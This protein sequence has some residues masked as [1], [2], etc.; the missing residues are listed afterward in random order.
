M[1]KGKVG[2]AAETGN[3]E[4]LR[5]SGA[6]CSKDKDDIRLLPSAL[7][8]KKRKRGPKKQKENKP[9]KPR[10]RK[11]LV[12]VKDSCLYNKAQETHFHRLTFS[13]VLITGAEVGEIGLKLGRPDFYPLLLACI[14]WIWDPNFTHY[15]LV[16]SPV[17]GC[18][19]A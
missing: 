8:V 12:S 9:G 6:L 13:V 4:K 17:F 2:G 14:S 1:R 15:N 5:F 18:D 16:K 10:K 7:G 19:L 3:L 11:K